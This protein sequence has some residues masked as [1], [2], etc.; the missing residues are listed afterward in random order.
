M[1]LQV[2]STGVAVGAVVAQAMP[3]RQMVPAKL[4]RVHM[5]S[6]TF[7]QDNHLR[8]QT[9]YCV[10]RLCSNSIIVAVMSACSMVATCVTVHDSQHTLML[11][12]ALAM[13]LSSTLRS[14]ST[15]L[16]CCCAFLSFSSARLSSWCSFAYVS[17]NPEGLLATCAVAA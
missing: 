14:P 17:C 10:Y 16:A 8:N 7:Q 9:S 6:H 13:P 4:N 2:C 15:S 11:L 3:L 1:D 5:Q 12:L